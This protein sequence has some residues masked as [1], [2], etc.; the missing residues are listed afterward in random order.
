MSAGGNM[1]KVRVYNRQLRSGRTFR[2]AVLISLIVA[3]LA[4]ITVRTLLAQSARPSATPFSTDRSEEL[5][6]TAT[7]N[8]AISTDD[9]EKSQFDSAF[10]T[11]L[12]N[13]FKTAPKQKH[14]S[15]RFEFA[16][17]TRVGAPTAAKPNTGFW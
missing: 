9:E 1:T 7:G 15:P 16:R 3:I 6:D 2:N 10:S 8:H 4:L 17:P 14:L 5:N 12:G 13:S 11:S